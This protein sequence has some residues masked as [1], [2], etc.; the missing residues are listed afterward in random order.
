MDGMSAL[1]SAKREL[2]QRLAS[3]ETTVHAVV[4]RS[5]DA[6]AETP[7]SRCYKRPRREGYEGKSKKKPEHIDAT[8]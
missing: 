1:E 2:R 7:R 6:K 8:V 3:H 4:A 5:I